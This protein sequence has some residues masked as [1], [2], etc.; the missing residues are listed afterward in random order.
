M[1]SVTLTA[2]LFEPL[3][4]DLTEFVG[5]RG[6][7]LRPPPV[8]AAYRIFGGQRSFSDTS[9]LRAALSLEPAPHL[10]SHAR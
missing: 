5:R 10:Y 9:L 4:L 8:S 7:R 2:D 6:K 1:K 3:Y